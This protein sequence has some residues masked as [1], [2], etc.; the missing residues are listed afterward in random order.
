MRKRGGHEAN[1]TAQPHSE[2]N[3]SGFRIGA[4]TIQSMM[5][6]SSLFCKPEQISH[7]P[8]SEDSTLVLK[9]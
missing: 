9:I 6:Q 8:S 5:W 4:K 3:Q 2:D 1:G 7:V